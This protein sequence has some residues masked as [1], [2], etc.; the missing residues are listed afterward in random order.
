M[1]IGLIFPKDSEA[2]FDSTSSETFG[3]A[4]VQ[5]F[6]IANELSKNKEDSIFCLIPKIKNRESLKNIQPKIVEV[7]NINKTIFGTFYIFHKKIKE[8]K[9]DVLIQHGLTI[10][11]CLL[12]L[13]CKIFKIK[14]AFMFASDTEVKGEY[15][16]SKK[17][18]RLFSLLLK[19]ARVLIVQNK[20][21][22][23]Y[24]SKKG[25]N[26]TL[27]YMGFS[28]RELKQIPKEFILWIGRCD[29]SKQPEL[30]INLAKNHKDQKFFMICPKTDEEFFNRI[31][32]IA[33]GVDNLNFIHFVA[34]QDTWNYFERAKL[35]VNT[36]KSEG[37]P[38]TFVQSVIC[39]VPIISLCV[40]PDDFITDN[41]CGF[42]CDG[43]TKLLDI[44]LSKALE[45]IDLYI[46]ISNNSLIYA[47]KKHNISKNILSI[48]DTL[49]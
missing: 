44:N 24:L 40:D 33:E 42:V 23:D 35:F 9:P 22:K 12:S 21:Q 30:F 17:K 6:I 15:Q 11:S 38:Q 13:Y 5:M 32:T 48:I 43:D 36:S 20:Y 31:K 18:C 8:E 49:K 46:K 25:I 26:S 37:F 34:F 7:F 28:I 45:D 10:F 4:T 39:G 1:K 47:N 2:I 14:F 19:T 27:I 41:K 3:G 29:A 16:S